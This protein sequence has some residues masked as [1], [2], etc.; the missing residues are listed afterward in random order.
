MSFF[1]AIILSFIEGITEFL[2]ISSTGHMILAAD[3]LKIAETDFVKSFEIIIQL[4]A[5]LAVLILY[6]KKIFL[7]R[8]LWPKILT[9]FLPAALV[10]LTLYKVIKNLLLGNTVIVLVSLMVGGLFLLI[11]EGIYKNKKNKSKNL[12]QLTIQDSLI[13]GFF[14]SLSVIPGVSRSAST[15]FGGLIIGLDR[16]SA[17]EFSFLLAIPTMFAATGLDLFKSSF[18]FTRSDSILL[19]IGF[20]GAF[21]TALFTVKLFTGFIQKHSLIPFAVY[22]IILSIIFWLLIIK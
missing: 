6:W 13:I 7:D 16:K 1:H 14:Q 5:I 21:I 15:I 17:V 4:G 20:L 22:R 2:P 3:I 11:L 18:S 9:A 8:T 12:S 10:G 19:V